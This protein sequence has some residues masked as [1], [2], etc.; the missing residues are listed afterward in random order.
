[1]VIAKQRWPVKVGALEE[2]V[3]QQRSRDLMNQEL[4]K[5]LFELLTSTPVKI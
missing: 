2:N 3:A 4:P 1:M 5:Q